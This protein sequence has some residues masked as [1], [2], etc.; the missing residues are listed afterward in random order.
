MYNSALFKKIIT[1]TRKDESAKENEF[2]SL[3]A[4]EQKQKDYHES[5]KVRK[6]ERK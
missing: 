2:K 3:K 6:D 4:K 5:T 1:K